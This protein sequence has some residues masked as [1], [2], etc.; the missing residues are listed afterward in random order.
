M[1]S[2]DQ[3]RINPLSF[4]PGGVTVRVVFENG[5]YTD[6]DKVHYPRKYIEVAKTKPNVTDAYVLQP[7]N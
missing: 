3:N 7:K 1:I 5:K 4:V 6:Y 2:L